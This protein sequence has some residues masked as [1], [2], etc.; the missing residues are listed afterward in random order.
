VDAV[1]TDYVKGVQ[2]KRDSTDFI[3]LNSYLPNDLVYTSK[4]SSPQFAVFS[5]IYYKDGWDAFIDGKPTDYIR[6]NYILRAMAIPAGTHTIEFKFEPKEFA[7]GE[8]V[9]LASSLLLIVGCV[10]LLFQ[11]FRPKKAQE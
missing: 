3:K 1:F 9:S 2:P 6:V 10:F 4:T 8:K 11:Q 5:E 7:I